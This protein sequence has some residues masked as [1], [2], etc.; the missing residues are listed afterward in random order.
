MSLD[1]RTL[2]FAAAL[3]RQTGA[4]PEAAWLSIVEAIDSVVFVLDAGGVIV[5][6]SRP[7]T[8]WI[9]AHKGG[10]E[11]ASFADLPVWRDRDAA[12]AVRAAL[13]SAL[14]GAVAH[15][16]AHHRDDRA[17]HAGIDLTFAPIRSVNGQ[18]EGC[19]VSGAEAPPRSAPRLSG[20]FADSELLELKTIYRSAPVGLA[21]I[22]RDLRVVRMN[23]ALAEINGF[24]VEEHI[25]RTIWDLVPDLRAQGEPLLRHVLATGETMSNLAFEGETKRAPGVVRHWIEHF[26][27][28]RDATG[29]IAGIGI[30]CE[31]V[32]EKR[33][34]E[35]ALRSE[36]NHLRAVLSGMAEGFLVLDPEFRI[37]EI[38]TEAQRIDGRPAAELLGRHLLEVWPEAEQMP[39]W[40]AY[41]K[42]M[43]D[44]VP[45]TVEYRHQSDVHD[46]WLDVRAFPVDV[47]LAVFYRDVT[48]R[49][50]SQME[51]EALNAELEARIRHAVDERERALG[52]FHE[53]QKMEAIGQLTGGVAHDFNNLLSAV[54]AN[55]TVLRKLVGHDAHALRLIDGAIQGA[56]RG[57]SLT[58]RLL[59]FAR[60]Q[61]LRATAVDVP[62]LIADMEDMLRR[63]LGPSIV[64]STQLE[65]GLPPVSADPN[66]LEL[67]LLN[68]AV[69]ARDAMPDGGALTVAA[70][71]E[72]VDFGSPTDLRP[73]CYVAISVI[74]TGLGMAPDVAAR[75]TEP[76]FTTKDVGQGTGLGLS[77]VQGFAGQSGGR[78][79][80]ESRRGAGT[81]VR[82]WLPC[83]DEAVTV[84]RIDKTGATPTAKR[85]LLVLV[86]DDDALVRMG[87]TAI[88]EDLGHA[89]IAA[90]SATEALAVLAARTDID[91]VLTDHGMPGMSGADLARRLMKERP[92]LPV[93]I[94]TGYADLPN[95]ETIG[96]PRLDKPIRQEELAA[97]LARVGG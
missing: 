82:V 63:T 93:I 21:L 31:E 18:C 58:R 70:R 60:R 11:G 67:A 83:S 69:N 30:I 76:F 26:Y 80:I 54:L 23:E 43:A 59:A 24:T 92:D 48:D 12:A 64:V 89:S 45:I 86:V 79:D 72:V 4:L 37:I 68:L 74:D 53:A 29:A 5:G 50:R 73:G 95:G 3:A 96:A 13:D 44:R 46:V 87:T 71:R 51:L 85:T 28:V 14:T 27:P 91:V 57:A 75:A 38:N 25:G 90:S 1:S 56:D 39:T 32:T 97:A 62:A 8:E 42:A 20:A 94:A 34:A 36:R 84:S 33:R 19:V 2:P 61:D 9:G 65:Q 52:L 15:C 6:A 17:M 10:M 47:G 7:A 40:P 35:D 81:H 66:Q 77:M 49:R 41:Q 22:D 88:I 55:L 16:T 78:L